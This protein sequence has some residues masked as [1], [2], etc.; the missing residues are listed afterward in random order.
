[1]TTSIVFS[2]L[3][4]GTGASV[5]TTINDISYDFF[6]PIDELLTTGGHKSPYENYFVDPSAAVEALQNHR[7]LKTRETGDQIVTP[8][9]SGR[10][11]KSDPTDIFELDNNYVNGNDQYDRYKM[12]R[13]FEVLK[14]NNNS[15]TF[16]RKQNYSNTV[17]NS[18]ISNNRLNSIIESTTSCNNENIYKPGINSGIKNNNTILYLDKNID[19]YSN[20]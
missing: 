11:R 8:N 16:T 18:Q 20:L 9:T 13:K 3:N 19:Y 4:Y 14:H 15:G 12:R 6:M 7:Y 2:D 10:T 5:D 17:T 1:M